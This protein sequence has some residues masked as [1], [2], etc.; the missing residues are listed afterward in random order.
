MNFESSMFIVICNALGFCL[1]KNI[2]FMA[3]EKDSYILRLCGSMCQLLPI[4]LSKYSLVSLRVE[5][6]CTP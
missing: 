4:I 6:T 2:L 1:W 5:V 3:K